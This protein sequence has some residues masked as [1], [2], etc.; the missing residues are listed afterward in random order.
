MDHAAPV[1]LGEGRGVDHV[2][3]KVGLAQEV[4][5]CGVALP[6]EELQHDR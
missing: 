5:A 3:Q 6:V 4:V 2:G 1:D